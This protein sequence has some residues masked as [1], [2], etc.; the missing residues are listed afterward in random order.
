MSEQRASVSVLDSVEDL[1]VVSQLMA[2]NSNVLAA[3]ATATV[4][5]A[6]ELM[7]EL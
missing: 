6:P 1:G 4:Y 2:A 7:S 5:R 3:T